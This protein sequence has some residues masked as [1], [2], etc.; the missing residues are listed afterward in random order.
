M[1]A[2]AHAQTDFKISNHVCRLDV[3]YPDHNRG[4][5][6]L[7]AKNVKHS[8]SNEDDDEDYNDTKT[9]KL[10]RSRFSRAKL[11]VRVNGL[12]PCMARDGVAANVFE[13]LAR[14]SR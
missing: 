14:R 9:V 6:S 2:S 12:G 13:S 8:P 3:A 4:A 7:L 10:L 11:E 5:K 1:A